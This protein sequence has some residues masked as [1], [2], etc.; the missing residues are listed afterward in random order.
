MLQSRKKMYEKNCP[1]LLIISSKLLTQQSP[2]SNIQ[3]TDDRSGYFIR[4]LLEQNSDLMRLRSETYFKGYSGF[5]KDQL[6]GLALLVGAA[7]TAQDL[8]D[9][10]ACVDLADHLLN[11]PLISETK[12][13]KNTAQ[14]YLCKAFNMGNEKAF[15]ILTELSKKKI[16]RDGASSIKDDSASEQLFQI[17]RLD[18]SGGD[19]RTITTKGLNFLMGSVEKRCKSDP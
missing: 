10:Q 9:S 4:P 16:S 3:E 6:M 11:N 2:H 1:F 15:E 17:I 5:D 19:P 7:D 8:R 18:V 12:A 13:A 14:E